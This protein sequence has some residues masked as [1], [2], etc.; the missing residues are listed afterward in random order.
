MLGKKG[1]RLLKF[2]TSLVGRVF[3]AKYYP[4]SS[5]LDAKLGCNPS[6]VWRSIL[7][8]QTLLK[9]GAR[10]RIGDGRSI[11]VVEHPW[12][13]DMQNPCII[14]HNEDLRGMTVDQLF[15]ICVRAWNEN[16]IDSLF[17]TRDR[18]AIY[19]V[20]K[21]KVA[22]I[23]VVC[24][25]IW[26]ARNEVIWNNRNVRAGN[27]V[28]VAVAYLSQWQDVQKKRKVTSHMPNSS[29]GNIERWTKPERGCVKINCDA[30]LFTSTSQFG[31]AWVVR[32]DKGDLIYANC[33]CF[34]GKPE[35][36][37]AEAVSIR[38]ALSWAKDAIDS[39]EESND[40]D[41]QLRFVVE[42]DC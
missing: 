27:V 18:R 3:K 30:A 2:E 25:N 29:P 42:S 21:E 11:S 8:T 12:L 23:S 16:V 19:D 26:R 10:W 13:T 7:E 32:N 6:Y 40:P 4:H 15:K 20:M 31:V 37:Y 17:V 33:R 28:S 14:T 38:E 36:H 1:W 39:R 34:V 22:K 41:L 5:F 9:R 35:S 24:W